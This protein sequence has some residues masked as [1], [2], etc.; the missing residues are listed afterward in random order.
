[1][2]RDYY[3]QRAG[4]QGAVR[5]SLIEIAD[6]T[7]SLFNGLEDQGCFQR[8]F[9]YYCTDAGVVAG[10]EPGTLLD[11]FYLAT[12]VRLV[13]PLVDAIRGLGEVELFTFIEYAFDHVSQPDRT[14][15][16]FHDWNDCG[17]H[18]DFARSR[19]DDAAG[20]RDWREK[21]NR[22]LRM[23]EDGFELTAGGEVTRLAPTGLNV[24]VAA[25]SP[26]TAPT[27]DLAKVESAVHT[28]MLAK[29]TREQKKQ[30][31]RTLA[32]IL[33][34]HRDAAKAHLGGDEQDLFNIANNF[35]LRHHNRNQKDDY[36]DDVLDLLFYQFL[37]AVRLILARV[38]IA[39]A[40]QASTPNDKG[41]LPF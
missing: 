33:E 25:P 9:G 18:F 39:A 11:E 23:Y 34:F 16:R 12:G 13:Y 36:A 37:A 8:S 26:P 32:D 15:G 19:F 20:R 30:A 4:L 2:A 10:R 24:L 21:L 40:P 27:T 41:D 5:L 31:V 17:W 1:M 7:S 29:S 22:F 3:N 28:F 14:T 6:R 35:A 38:S